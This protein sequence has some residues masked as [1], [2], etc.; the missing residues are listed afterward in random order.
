MDAVTPKQGT[1]SQLFRAA[2]SEARSRKMRRIWLITSNDNLEAVKFYERLGMRVCA[3]HRGAIDEARK[4]KPSIPLV[5]KNGLPIHD[6]IELELM[7]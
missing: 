4:L 7:L 5:A 6:E 3:V 1:G 2:L